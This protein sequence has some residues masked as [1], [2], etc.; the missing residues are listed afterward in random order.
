MS[1]VT[2]RVRIRVE[3]DGTGPGTKLFGPDGKPLDMSRIKSVMWRCDRTG[4]TLTVEYL[5]AAIDS[6]NRPK[7]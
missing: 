5:D 2:P 6:T 7:L 4:A 3:S 1:K